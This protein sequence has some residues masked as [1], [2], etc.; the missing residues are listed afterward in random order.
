MNVTAEFAN[1]EHPA[2]A[3]AREMME[4]LRRRVRSLVDPLGVRNAEELTE[5]LVMLIDG[6]FSSAQVFG[7]DGPHR[8]LVAAAD[9]LVD[10]QLTKNV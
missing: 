4:E 6:A 2:R 5:Q 9:A 3:V 7:K 1:P 8:L 10:S